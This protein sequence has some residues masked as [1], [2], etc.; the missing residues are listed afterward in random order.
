[1]WPAVVGRESGTS[2]SRTHLVVLAIYR[3]ANPETVGWMDW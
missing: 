3:L 1:M 2:Y